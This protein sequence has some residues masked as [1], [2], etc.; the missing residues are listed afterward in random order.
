MYGKL[1]L[2]CAHHQHLPQAHKAKNWQ[3]KEG[4]ATKVS[5]A[6]IQLQELMPRARVLYCSAT[7]VWHHSGSLLQQII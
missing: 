6:V 1:V 3:A 5:M 4:A 2:L 7:G